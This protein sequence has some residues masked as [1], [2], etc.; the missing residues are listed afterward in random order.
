MSRGQAAAVFARLAQAQVEQGRSW[1]LPVHQLCAV[2]P[3]DEQFRDVEQ[4]SSSIDLTVSGLDPGTVYTVRLSNIDDVDGQPPATGPVHFTD[5]DG[6]G[7]ADLRGSQ[8]VVVTANGH[9][10]TSRDRADVVADRDGRI[11]LTVDN[12]HPNGAVLVVF[13]SD[14]GV[15]GLQ[16]TDDGTAAEPFGASGDLTWFVPAV[17][18]VPA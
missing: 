1:P 3:A 12:E 17:P 4:P 16:V 15:R 7:T 10:A 18:A 9:P 8:A 13:E 6:D 5:R 14:A 11:G 2:D